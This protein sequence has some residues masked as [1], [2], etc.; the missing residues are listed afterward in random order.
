MPN[1]PFERARHWLT[2]EGSTKR[3]FGGGA[4]AATG[5]ASGNPL[6]GTRLSTVWTNSLFETLLSART[7]AYL[8]DHQVQGSPVTPAATESPSASTTSGFHPTST[9]A[10]ASAA[11]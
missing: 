7:P 8:F 1:Y 3:S 4:V 11:G 5:E 2:F 9:A 10:A 6:L